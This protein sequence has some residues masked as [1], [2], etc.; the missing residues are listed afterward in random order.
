MYYKGYH[1]LPEGKIIFDLIK[2]KINKNRLTSNT[3]LNNEISILDIESLL[4]KLSLLDSPYEIKK[5]IRYYKNT[6]KL[7]SEAVNIT[8][9]N[10]SNNNRVIYK[11]ISD[12]AKELQISR[13]NIRN[14]LETGKS[15][16][17]YSF[18]LN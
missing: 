11:S 12:C 15:Y 1:T 9:I 3:N 2:S 8:V 14:C 4:H 16:K 6:T 17:G 5:G 18:V 7:V 13:R 10:S